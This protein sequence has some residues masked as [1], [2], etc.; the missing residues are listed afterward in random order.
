[1]KKTI[2]TI[3]REFGS[4]G[5]F[6]GEEVAKR[7]NIPYYDKDII[8]QIAEKTIQSLSSRNNPNML[9]RRICLPMRL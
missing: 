9:H 5:H 3:S 7:M 2:I 1:M 4:G 6:I 8:F